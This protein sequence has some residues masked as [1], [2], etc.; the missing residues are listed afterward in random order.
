MSKHVCFILDWYP[1]KTNNGCV[2]VK[3]LICAIADR[4]VKCTVIAPMIGNIKNEEVPYKRVEHTEKGSEIVIYTPKY[5]HLGSKKHFIK[6]SMHNHFSSVMKVIKKHNLCR[7]YTKMGN[8]Y[9]LFLIFLYKILLEK[10]CI[11]GKINIEV[12]FFISVKG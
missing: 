5:T 2:F 7:N 9:R 6:I 1:T 10:I 4:G 3:Y 11:N 8:S 12:V